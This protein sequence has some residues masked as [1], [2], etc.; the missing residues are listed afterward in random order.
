MGT[1]GALAAANVRFWPTVAPTVQRELRGWEGCAEQIPDDALRALAREKL[2]GER[3]NTEVAATLA[4]LAP[5]RVRARATRA[6]VSLELLFD[7]LDGRTESLTGDPLGEGAELFAPFIDAVAVAGAEPT[8]G[9]AAD[10]PAGASARP[11]D[12]QY[13]TALSEA[14]REELRALPASVRVAGV[15]AHSA[16]RCA[17]A[18]VRLHAAPALGDEQLRA[19][20]VEQSA[21]SGLGW[22]EYVAGCA[23]SVLAMHA[24]IAAAATSSR[25]EAEAARIDRAY[26]A[27]GAVITTLDS[28]VDHSEDIAGGRPGFIRLYEPAELPGQMRELTR[29]ALARTAEA[30]DATHHAMT[31]AGVAAYYTTHPG[32][33]DPHVR[34]VTKVVRGELSPTIW[35]TLAVLRGWRAAKALRA[36]LRG[37]RTRAG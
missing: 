10:G 31:L 15:V 9:L 28:L 33:N 29:E 14:S 26:L 6:I 35:P 30:P 12:W 17:E 32:A 7:Y 20:A 18:Q 16:R 34:E 1:V 2:V 21:G 19:W 13:L 36:A 37:A 27:I 25:T 23:S 22:R 4:T 8:R 3:F 11:G 24:L 5:R